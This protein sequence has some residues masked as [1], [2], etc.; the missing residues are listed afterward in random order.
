MARYPFARRD[1]MLRRRRGEVRRIADERPHR[2][3]HRKH[4]VGGLGVALLGATMI[5]EPAPRLLWNVSDSAPA[6]L[7][8]VIPQARL[9]RGDMVVAHVP[10]S[11]RRLAAERHYLPAN[12]PLLKRIAAVEGDHVCAIGASVLINGSPL[13]TRLNEDRRGRTMPWWTDCETLGRGRFLLLMSE[14]AASF[15]GRYFGPVAS[16]QIVGKA[17][18]LWAR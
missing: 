8:R 17:V 13:A 14:H 6:G 1:M 15:D 3:R 12:V 4:F 9:R 2:Y 7:Y 18:L 16:R 11:V 10:A 5:W